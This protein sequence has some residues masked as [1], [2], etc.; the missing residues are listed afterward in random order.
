MPSSKRLVDLAI[1]APTRERGAGAV[2]GRDGA[3]INATPPGIFLYS[4]EKRRAVHKRFDN[5]QIVP[6]RGRRCCAP[7]HPPDRLIDR[8]RVER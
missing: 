1:A 2:A 7:G 3:T 8:D 5:V 6:I 4:L